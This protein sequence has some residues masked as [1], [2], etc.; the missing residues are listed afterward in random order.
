MD[1]ARLKRSGQLLAP[2]V[3]TV[4]NMACG[5]F[6]VLAASWG[7]FMSAG[8]A[9]LAGIV[10]D[11]LDGRVARLVHGESQFGAEFD[12]LADFLIFGV[13]PGYM[14]YELFLKDYGLPGGI[15]AFGYV[16]CAAM[17]LAR[18]NV[19]AA[20]G[21][22]SKTS[23]QGLPTPA[24]AGFLASLV[25]LYTIVEQDRAGRT[26]PVVMAFVPHLV[27]LSPFVVLGLGFLMISNVPY[28]AAKQTNLLDPK[29]FKLLVAVTLGGC[30]LYFYPQNAI[31]LLFLF[32]VISGF[33]RIIQR[34]P[35]DGS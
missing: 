18:F 2:T 28:F 10:F 3:F 9:I 21:K 25:L 5:F 17:R 4:A 19:S 13:A 1:R 29:H 15:A 31:F 24:A 22:G 34:P 33:T 20:D 32:Y 12:S 6:A 27:N 16:L 7:D 26:I 35:S 14:M 11:L 23:F 30:M 8:T